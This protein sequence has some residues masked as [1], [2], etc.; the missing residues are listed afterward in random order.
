MQLPVLRKNSFC[1]SYVKLES[2]DFTKIYV[3]RQSQWQLVLF[4]AQIN[5]LQTVEQ[6]D[7]N[8]LRY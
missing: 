4:R 8:K 3:G 5:P 1:F 6:M 2:L 7:K